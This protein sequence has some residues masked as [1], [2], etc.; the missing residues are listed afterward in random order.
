MRGVFS[1]G[2]EVPGPG[3]GPSARARTDE[4]ALLDRLREAERRVDLAPAAERFRA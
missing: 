1:A 3:T 2:S 4:L